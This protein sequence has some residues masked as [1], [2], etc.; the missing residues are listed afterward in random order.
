ML[1]QE[2][3]LSRVAQV[4]VTVQDLDRAVACYRD[5]LGLPLLLH[6]SN[7]AIFDCAGMRL[8]LSPPEGEFTNNASILYFDVPSVDDA[9][10]ALRERG[11]E[12][13]DAPHKVADWGAKQL[14]MTFFRDSERNAMA[15]VEERVVA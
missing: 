6:V 5:Q 12:F 10:A 7:L 3:A 1:Q 2:F 9:H 11:I 14:W 8:M 13:I 15:L 4:A